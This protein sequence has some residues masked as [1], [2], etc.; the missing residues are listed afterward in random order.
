MWLLFELLLFV[1]IFMIIWKIVVFVYDK[2]NIAELIFKRNRR[3]NPYVFYIVGIGGY[4]LIDFIFDSKN[5]KFLQIPN[6]SINILTLS[7]LIIPTV[8]FV[9]G[10]KK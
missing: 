8:A 9:Y 5:I 1:T 3:V 10:I 2:Y 7:F 4:C 6:T